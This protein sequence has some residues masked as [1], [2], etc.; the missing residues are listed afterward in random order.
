[1][2]V[3]EL[4]GN[5]DAIEGQSSDDVGLGEVDGDEREEE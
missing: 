1:M 5:E 2:V 3:D 4:L